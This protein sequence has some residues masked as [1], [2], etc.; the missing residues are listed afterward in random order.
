MEILE[1]ANPAEK[2]AL[3][4]T[5]LRALPQWF[6]NEAARVDYVSRVRDAPF[7]AAYE[8]GAAVGFLALKEHNAYTA[9]IMVMG[10][11]PE[12]HRRGVGAALVRACEQ[13]CR[14]RKIEYLTVKTL[15]ASSGYEPYEGTRRFYRKAG[16]RPLEVFPLYWDK[17]NPCLLMA[18]YIGG[19]H[20]L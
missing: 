19:P 17:D 6:G 2:S 8:D 16:F 10:V 13:S 15:D 12:Y 3:C 9:E 7:F 1:L 20:V 11:L 14:A 4:D 5:V 18:N